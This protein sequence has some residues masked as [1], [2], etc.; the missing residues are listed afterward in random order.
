MIR[1]LGRCWVEDVYTRVSAFKFRCVHRQFIYPHLYNT[2]VLCVCVCV[3]RYELVVDAKHFR[4]ESTELVSERASEASKQGKCFGVERFYWA[5]ANAIVIYYSWKRK[6]YAPNV[7]SIE[8]LGQHKEIYTHTHTPSTWCMKKQILIQKKE[9][10]E[11]E[12]YIIWNTLSGK[13][14]A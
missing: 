5:N 6:N 7:F 14:W 4:G 1:I 2:H 11:T 13:R 8:F 10:N 12:I 9:D 3:W